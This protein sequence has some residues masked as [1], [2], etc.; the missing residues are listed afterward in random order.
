MPWESPGG[1]LGVP[2]AHPD[3]PPSPQVPKSHQVCEAGVGESSA[4]LGGP[5]PLRWRLHCWEGTGYW[6]SPVWTQ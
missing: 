6:V 2:Y 3:I 4:L 5:T 1:D